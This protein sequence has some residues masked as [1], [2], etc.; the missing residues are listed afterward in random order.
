MDGVIRENEAELT[1]V[2]QPPT[3]EH[4]E[5]VKSYKGGDTLVIEA[6]QVTDILQNYGLVCSVAE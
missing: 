5:K 3:I 1:I 4:W 6:E 2:P